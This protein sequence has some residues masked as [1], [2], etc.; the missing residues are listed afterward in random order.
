LKRKRVNFTW[1][2]EDAQKVFAEWV[3]FPDAQTSAK[4]VDMIERFVGLKPPMAIPVKNW[5]EK[6][7]KLILTEKSIKNGYRDEYCVV[8]DTN[9]LDDSLP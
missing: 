9:A 8:I 6:N 2:S 3:P 5:H 7:G 1:E 4:D